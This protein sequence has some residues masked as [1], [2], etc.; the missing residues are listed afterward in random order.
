MS[1][2]N[3]EIISRDY[4]ISIESMFEAKSLISLAMIEICSNNAGSLLTNSSSVDLEYIWATPIKSAAT[5]LKSNCFLSDCPF[6]RSLDEDYTEVEEFD[7]R[8]TYT[9]VV[10]RAYA[11]VE[12]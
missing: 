10:S 9:E 6:W 11:P 1:G 8:V 3:S 5:Y 12:S 7:D 4:S 2:T